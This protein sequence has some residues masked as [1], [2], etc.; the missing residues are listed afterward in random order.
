M[1]IFCDAADMSSFEK[2]AKD[3]R[4]SGFTSNPSL[5]KK[6]G[7]KDYAAFAKDVLSIIGPKE[8][9][10]EVLADDF[11]EMER[12]ASKI[13]SWGS[14]VWVKIPITNT[15]GESS[16]PLIKKIRRLQLNI[17]AVMTQTQVDDMT[18]LLDERHILSIFM[19]RRQDTGRRSYLKRDALLCRTLWASTRCVLDSYIAEEAG[20][21]I[22]TLTPDLIEKLELEGRD[23][24]EYSLA[25]VRQF[26]H[27]G[28]GFSL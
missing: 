10:F 14:N 23:L 21:S 22:C 19:G 17:T 28:Q 4:I 9:S 12:Q 13:A 25:T 2:Y 5:M 24:T 16:A 1:V 6:A 3:E 8:I 20:Y 18:H 15:K 27:D 26:F 11:V 7:V